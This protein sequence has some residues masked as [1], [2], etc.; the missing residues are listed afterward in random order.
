MLEFQNYGHISESQSMFSRI[1]KPYKII[2]T[3]KK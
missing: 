2:T 1:K 3:I